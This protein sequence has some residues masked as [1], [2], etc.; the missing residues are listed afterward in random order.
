MIRHIPNLLTLINLLAGCISVAFIFENNAMGVLICWVIS[1]VC[2]FADGLIARMLKLNSSLGVQLDSLAD[3]VSF[4]LVPGAMMYWMIENCLTP[5]ID[6]WGVSLSLVGFILTL[7][8]AVRLARFNLDTRQTDGF[9][10]LPTPSAATFVLGMYMMVHYTESEFLI[11]QL[12]NPGFLM[13]VTILLSVLLNS[14]LPMFALKFKGLKWVGNEVKWVAIAFGLLNLFMFG[15]FAFTL[16]VLL[17]VL[18]S[19]GVW[20]SKR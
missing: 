19:L 14:P 18:F 2:D 13:I 16:N 6:F 5:K 10:G 9:I 17:Y 20:A 1:I 3:M 4:G 7:S 12:N 11:A 8:S 15:Y